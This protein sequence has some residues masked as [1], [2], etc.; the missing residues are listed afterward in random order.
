MRQYLGGD[1]AE[2]AENYLTASGTLIAK[3]GCPPTLMVHGDRDI[4]V[5][6]KQSERL[7]AKLESVHVPHYHLCAAMGHS[8]LRLPV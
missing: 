8:R 3:E 2:A 1:A 7:A 6:N 5:W 4:L